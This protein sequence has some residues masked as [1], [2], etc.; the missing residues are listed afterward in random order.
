MSTDLLEGRVSELEQRARRFKLATTGMEG[1]ENYFQSLVMQERDFLFEVLAHTIA[2]FHRD[3]I[4]EAR[5]MLDEAL[6][7]RVR[8]TYQ[9]STKYVRGDVVVL[10]GGSFLAR[11]DS[12][13]PC[14]GAGWQLMAKQG[15]RGVAGP[16]GE[17]GPAGKT[18]TG[19]IVDRGTY[20]VT[21]RMSDGSLGAPLELRALFE[22]DEDNVI[23]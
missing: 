9:G 15:Q 22:Q 16:Q 18:I 10:D 3:I 12:P 14:P 20:C 8:G 5:A 23:A 2:Q 11:C 1:W 13:G 4:D 19:W 6:S 17:R 21:P 7:I